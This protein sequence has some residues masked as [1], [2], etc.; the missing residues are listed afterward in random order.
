[1]RLHPA[2]GHT[3]EGTELTGSI[4]IEEVASSDALQERAVELLDLHASRLGHHFAPQSLCLTVTDKDAAPPRV[5]GALVG[6]T[7]FGWLY[8]KYLAV[9]ASLRGQGF[10]ARLIARA[11]AIAR[12]RGCTAVWLDTFSFQAPGFYR[13]MGYAEFGRLDDYPKGHA[14]HFFAKWLTDPAP[15]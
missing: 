14:R 11:E 6:F 3:D 8:V 15:R 1:M 13:K 12:E 10:G 4:A 2:S 5:L 7:N 9:D